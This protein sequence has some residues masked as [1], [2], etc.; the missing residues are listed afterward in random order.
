MPQNAQRPAQL[1]TGKHKCGQPTRILLTIELAVEDLHSAH[2]FPRCFHAGFF[3]WSGDGG[4]LLAQPG[5]G[6]FV[7]EHVYMW[8]VDD[9]IAGL[10]NAIAVVDILTVEEIGFILPT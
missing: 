4:R 3:R 7:M 10:G 9:L 5:T 2:G 8:V 1:Y 6:S